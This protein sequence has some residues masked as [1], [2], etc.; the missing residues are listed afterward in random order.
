[1]K[2]TDLSN[3]ELAQ[4]FLKKDIEYERECFVQD[5]TAE[6]LAITHMVNKG[7]IFHTEKIQL[8]YLPALEAYQYCIND[9][10]Y[11]KRCPP[12]EIR[13]LCEYLCQIGK[14]QH[15]I[16]FANY[17]KTRCAAHAANAAAVAAYAAAD[18]AATAA[19]AADAADAAAA[20]AA[21]YAADARSRTLKRCATIV[22]R[23]FSTAP[24]LP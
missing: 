8:K 23:H 22:R 11:S 1:M 2:H 6:I 4:C 12:L 14:Y 9:K 21:A 13:V 7:H 3:L 24:V 16:A 10:I 19:D 17:I 5:P 18:A 20:D 15:I